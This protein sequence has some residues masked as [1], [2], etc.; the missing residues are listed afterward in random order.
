MQLFLTSKFDKF[1]ENHSQ[2]VSRPWIGGYSSKRIRRGKKKKYV[3]QAAL[4]LQNKK[5]AWD[6]VS[7]ELRH[8][9][10]V[11]EALPPAR[12]FPTSLCIWI[13]VWA[14]NQDV[15]YIWSGGEGVKWENFILYLF[16]L[17]FMRIAS[18]LSN[19]DRFIE[20]FSFS[21]GRIDRK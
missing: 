11:S 8:L 14:L 12:R 16:W 3:W 5:K 7:K 15:M 21:N 9:R 6:E 10:N 13:V 2:C 4:K 1:P 19:E 17:N 18:S 20:R